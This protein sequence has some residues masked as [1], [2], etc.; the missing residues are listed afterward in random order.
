VLFGQA[1][2]AVGLCVDM[3]FCCYAQLGDEGKKIKIKREK[4]AEPIDPPDPVEPVLSAR[5]GLCSRQ[6]CRPD[7]SWWFYC[8][9]CRQCSAAYRVLYRLVSSVKA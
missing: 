1:G 9:C 8:A 6:F 5:P 2:R 3:C 7:C 4:A